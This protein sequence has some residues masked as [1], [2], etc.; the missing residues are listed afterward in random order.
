MLKIWNISR[1]ILPTICVLL[2]L[3]TPSDTFAEKKKKKATTNSDANVEEQTESK[4]L[5]KPAEPDQVE[6]AILG[7]T[8]DYILDCRA[9]TDR[10]WEGIAE[11]EARKQ[12]RKRSG[13]MLSSFQLERESVNFWSDWFGDGDYRVSFVSNLGMIRLA[14][15]RAH[16]KYR[17]F[18][19]ADVEDKHY[20][21]SL[22]LFIRPEVTEVDDI[23]AAGKI[24]HVVIRRRKT[25]REDVIQPKA[26]SVETETFTNLFG[27]TL[28]ANSAVAEFDAEEVLDIASRGDVEAV[29]VIG[30]GPERHCWVDSAKLVQTFE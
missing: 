26:L 28:A 23:V 11:H 15:H 21:P 12:A 10:Q 2:A 25:K 5:M 24:K 16:E 30:N 13:E 29:I 4:A 6:N 9:R 17:E 27:A 14:A 22:T 20:W 3:F 7:E 1:L 18:T 19:I 8:W